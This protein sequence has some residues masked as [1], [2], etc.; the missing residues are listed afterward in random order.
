MTYSRFPRRRWF[1][2][3]PDSGVCSSESAV[4][5]LTKRLPQV[6]IP[7]TIITLLVA[8][9]LL[10]GLTGI[11][12]AQPAPWKSE[13]GYENGIPIGTKITQANWQQYQ[14][15]MTEG[16]KAVFAG[17][18]FWHMPRNVEIDVGPTRPIP[19]PKPYLQD[20]EKYSSQVTLEPLPDGGYVPKGY[21]A[22]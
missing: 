7:P 13:K 18:N 20:T 21:V 3:E 11:V 10:L 6:Q 16:M 19:A 4:T 8:A 5:V 9:P 17:T 1:S 2:E 14:Q 12:H 22:G 15:F